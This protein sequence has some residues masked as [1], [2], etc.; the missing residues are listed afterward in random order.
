MT[1]GKP[2]AGTRTRSSTRQ[3]PRASTSSAAASTKTS[4]PLSSA[5][6]GTVTD[7]TY[8]GVKVPNGG[9][10]ILE[11]PTREAAMEWAAKLAVACRCSQEVRQFQDDPQS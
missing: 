8:P 4:R 11:L 1:S 5:A 7:G 9:Y 2:L 3:R 6:D 10:C